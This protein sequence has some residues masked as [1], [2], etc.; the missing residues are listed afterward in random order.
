MPFEYVIK[1]GQ[2]EFEF[3]ANLPS[4]QDYGISALP[5]WNTTIWL[6]KKENTGLKLRFG[7]PCPQGGGLLE[8]IIYTPNR[9]LIVEK[10]VTSSTRESK[11]LPKVDK[12]T[13]KQMRIT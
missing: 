7:T 9:S 6:V 10:V 13:E 1:E 2:T 11:K 12:R 4:P 3:K 8:L 5:N